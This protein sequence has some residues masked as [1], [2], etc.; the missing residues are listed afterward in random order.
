M[1]LTLP[2]ML[3]LH[4]I[5]EREDARVA[6][7]HG[8]YP[9]TCDPI[10][11]SF[12]FC[13]INREHDRV[14]RWV[15]EHVRDNPKINGSKSCLVMSLAIA[16]VFN[17]PPTL[18]QIL[19]MRSWA[20]MR[21]KVAEL[22][23]EGKVFRGAYKMPAHGSGGM[24]VSSA[25]YFINGLQQIGAMD[26]EKC[27]TLESVAL[28]IQDARG[29]GPFLA[30]QV[31][32]DLRYT[33]HFKDAP[34]W[35]TF[36]LCGPGTKKGL[37]RF[38]QKPV[39]KGGTQ[40]QAA[41]QLREARAILAPHLKSPFNEYFKDPNNVTNSFCEFSKYARTQDGGSP[42]KTKYTPYPEN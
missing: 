4:F 34:D 32:T 10:I 14:T 21:T 7:E 2:Q 25:D 23:K 13:N 5:A 1:S 36:V 27:V 37:C 35:E 41:I 18:Q 22:K 31:T 38:F 17:H 3:F 24:N 33:K 12:K 9:H 16:R 19:P 6:K 42:P 26:F 28:K 29:F 30:N 40:N 20:V 8:I 11:Q 15:K 39:R